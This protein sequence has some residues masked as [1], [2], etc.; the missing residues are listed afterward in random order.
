MKLE[1]YVKI[2]T[3]EIKSQNKSC[4]TS[5]M[6]DEYL[7]NIYSKAFPHFGLGNELLAY[8]P[9]VWATKTE[10]NIWRLYQGK[11]LQQSRENEQ[12]SE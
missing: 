3:L 6:L 11:K 7:W 2:C 8:T 1:P 5:E 4:E 12:C 9:K 10:I